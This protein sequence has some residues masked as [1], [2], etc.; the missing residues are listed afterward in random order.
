MVTS[1]L[2]ISSES[3]GTIPEER[4]SSSHLAEVATTSIRSDSSLIR[5]AIAFTRR[6]EVDPVPSPTLM[7][8]SMSPAACSAA[9]I[10]ALRFGSGSADITDSPLIRW[11]L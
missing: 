8:D 2:P 7:P 1:S 3:S 6:A 9:A 11:S 5:R 4:A 10:F